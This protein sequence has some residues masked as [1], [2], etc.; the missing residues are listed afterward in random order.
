MV[1]VEFDPFGFSVNDLRRGAK[2]LRYDNTGDLYPLFTNNPTT[3]LIKSSVFTS[4]SSYLWH[5]RLGHLGV[6][7]LSSLSSKMLIDCNKAST[8]LGKHSKLPFS[9]SMSYTRLPFDIIHSDL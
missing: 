7:V 2:L 9:D 3:S 8:P 4:H 6:V 5:N 1:S